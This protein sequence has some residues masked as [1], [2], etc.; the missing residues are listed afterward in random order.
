MEGQDHLI[1]AIKDMLDC[2]NNT[3][4]NCILA[5]FSKGS[6]NMQKNQLLK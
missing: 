5:G 2:L 3:D 4:Y 6:A 1:K